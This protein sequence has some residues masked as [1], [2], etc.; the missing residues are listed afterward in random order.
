MAEAGRTE[1]ATPK[2]REEARKKGQVVLSPDVGAV[3]ALLAALMIATWGWP[4]LLGQ[5]RSLL[6]GWLEQ[7][8]LSGDVDRVWPLLA[9]SFLD[10]GRVLAPFALAT[11]L[12]GVAAVVAQIGFVMHPERLAPE[13]ERISPAKGMKRVFSAHGAMNLLK[14]ILKV[15]VTLG[16]GYVVVRRVSN[17]AAATPGMTVE[18]ILAF[19]G[20]GMRQLLIALVLALAA[21]AG[22][23]YLWQ[24]WKHE[25]DLKMTR[26]EVRDE[27][28]ESE[29][30][31]HV[32]LRFRR[33]HRELAKRRMLSDVATAD[34]VLTNPTHYAVALRYRS[35]EMG[36]PRVV[37]K[38]AGELAARIKD[39]ARAAGVPIVERRALAR[40][41]FRAV[42]VGAEIPP[43]LYRAVAE[44]L[45]FVYAVRRRT[46][47]ATQR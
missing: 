34:V 18:G 42:K 31:P 16:I 43:A 32:R 40:A 29:G 20:E 21:L 8:A 25:Q 30:D 2:R 22:L 39:A 27:L 44:I 37:A 4:V 47:E 1:Q 10:T 33:A 38:G 19:T 45:A 28:K 5:C 9:R 36:A 14:A 46:A 12:V 17:E 7:V 15:A 23:D 3:S 24:R 26:H 6:V 11:G 41:L 35:D 13:L